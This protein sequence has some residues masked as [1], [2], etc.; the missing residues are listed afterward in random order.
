MVREGWAM[1]FTDHAVEHKFGDWYYSQC[2]SLIT[3]KADERTR[4][5]GQDMWDNIDQSLSPY[6]CSVT[7]NVSGIPLQD[8]FTTL[9]GVGDLGT[10][11]ENYRMMLWRNNIK[12]LHPTQAVEI[13]NYFSQYHLN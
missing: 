13:D 8:L 6:N 1:A 2:Q 4:L 10:N 5:L 7:D 12:A 11:S 3:M 9:Q